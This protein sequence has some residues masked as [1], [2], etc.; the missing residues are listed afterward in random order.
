[1]VRYRAE[2]VG[3]PEAEFP[4]HEG[5]VAF[6]LRVHPDGDALALGWTITE[7]WVHLNG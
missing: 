1:M 2:R 6:L 7:F 3:Y 5:A 4:T